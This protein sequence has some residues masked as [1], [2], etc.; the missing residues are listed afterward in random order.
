MLHRIPNALVV[1]IIIL[2]IPVAYFAGIGFAEFAIHAGVAIGL[3]VLFAFLFKGSLAISKLMGALGLWIGFEPGLLLI[4]VSIALI[5]MSLVAVVLKW[6]SDS[7]D[8]KLPFLPFGVLA[9]A[10]VFPYTKAGTA[11]LS[12]V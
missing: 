12:L 10:A 4:F 8:T 6:T 7:A 5:A 3:M 9:F 1:A 11:V 2:F